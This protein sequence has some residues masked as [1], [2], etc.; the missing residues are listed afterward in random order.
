[1]SQIEP[2]TGNAGSS[3]PPPSQRKS[4]PTWLK[5]N[6]FT[7]C[8]QSLF[9]VVLVILVGL[10]VYNVLHWVFVTADWSVIPPNF[11]LLLSGQYP[12]AELWRI[13][14]G[15]LTFALLLGASSGTWKGVI[16]HLA[17]FLAGLFLVCLVLPFV[18]LETR[19]WLGSGIAL[20]GVGHLLGRLKPA[21]KT[22]AVAWLVFIPF[23]AFLLD[24]FGVLNSVGTNLWGGFLLTLLL[25]SV[26]I[27]CSFPLGLLLA[28]GR[29]SKLPAVKYTCITYIELIRGVPLITILFVA[30]IM[31]PL[32]LGGQTTIDHIAR[33]MIGLTLFNAAYLAENIR[34]GLQAIPRGQFEAS[35]ALGMSTALTTVFVILP[36]ALRAV[37]PT[38]V[39]QFIAIFKDT[40]LV[41]I[42]GLVDLLGIARNIAAN[43]EFIGR[44]ME[45][46]IFVALVFFIF[47]S[48]LSYT[49]RRVER[50]LG[51]G[52]R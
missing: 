37:I 12:V 20:I 22:M 52:D 21:K 13:W 39:G 42:V 33:A 4:V 23:A 46:F 28:L 6:L 41:A 26:A 49:S 5:D 47:C 51:V 3:L 2:Q 40:S 35:H 1:M 11:K 9:T 34:G 43:P 16:T 38:M 50:S 19:I 24:G 25:A 32:L 27:V 29:R 30:Q 48:I 18:A 10:L 36:Q 17:L 8:R 7:N 44:Q 15:L 31:L 45:L 14:V